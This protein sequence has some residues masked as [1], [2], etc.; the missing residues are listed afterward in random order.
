MPVSL[1]Q[2]DVRCGAKAANLGALLG[3]GFTVPNGVVILPDE[4]W[5]DGWLDGLG[6]GPFV[7]RS[8]S[9][10]EDSARLSFAG[11]FLSVLG[12]E[13]SAVG[14]AVRR[15]AG[16]GRAPGV[17][18]YAARHGVQAEETIPVLVQDQICAEVAGAIVSGRVDPERWVIDGE[19][20][21]QRAGSRPT[22]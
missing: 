5:D 2:A 12:V 11:Q 10:A 20:A 18:A 7:V 13:S 21:P 8:S 16:S 17:R 3:A 19:A 22:Y 1:S 6:S 4:K 15:V 14:D 9:H